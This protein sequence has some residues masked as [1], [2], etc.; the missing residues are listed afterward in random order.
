MRRSPVLT[1]QLNQRDRA[2]L[3]SR[4]DSRKR[5]AAHAPVEELSA[6]LAAELH[7]DGVSELEPFHPT[8][9]W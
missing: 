4:L 1:G 3:R 8:H 2:Q 9:G 7:V 5:E 6:W